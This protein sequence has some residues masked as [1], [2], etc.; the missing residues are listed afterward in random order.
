MV[1][2]PPYIACD[3]SCLTGIDGLGYCTNVLDVGC[4][5]VYQA[6]TCAVSC[7]MGFEADPQLFICGKYNSLLVCFLNK[8]R[9]SKVACVYVCVCV[10]TFCNAKY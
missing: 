5:N 10:R 8:C 9:V 4:C 3:P 6:N 1:P 7:D 2:L